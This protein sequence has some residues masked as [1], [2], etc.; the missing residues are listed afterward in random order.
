MSRPN[1]LN[2]AYNRLSRRMLS[3]KEME[4]ALHSKG[5]ANEEIEDTLRKLIETGL[6]NDF[7]LAQ[8]LYRQYTGKKFTGPSLLKNIMYKR[9]IACEA[10]SF[11][12]RDYGEEKEREVFELF[13]QRISRTSPYNKQKIVRQI[14]RKGFSSK[15][16]KEILFTTSE[17]N[18]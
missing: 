3:I 2:Y 15:Y 6:L 14:Q 18:E 4:R 13:L 7:V 12:M 10:I 16:I 17:E 11:A 1:P 9:E 5:Y 8:N